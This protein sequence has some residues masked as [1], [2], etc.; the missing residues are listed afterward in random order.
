MSPIV[1][2]FIEQRDTGLYEKMVEDILSILEFGLGRYSSRLH[3]KPIITY[4][5]K[6][7]G[8]L[9]RKIEKKNNK[10]SSINE[11]TDV[12]GIRIIAYF[13]DDVDVIKKALSDVF[14]IDRINSIDKRNQVGNSFGYASLHLV[15]SLGRPYGFKGKLHGPELYGGLRFEIQIRTILEHAWAEIE[16]DI[17]YKSELAAGLSIPIKRGLSRLAAVLETVDVE[18]IRV[19]IA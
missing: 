6:E 9:E 2:T 4:R 18:F 12:I 14:G 5:I 16:H 10:Y 17:G 8:S 15:A 1:N 13:Q 7:Q 11:I 3:A 19:T